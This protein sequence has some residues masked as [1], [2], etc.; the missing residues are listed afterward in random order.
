MHVDGRKEVSVTLQVSSDLHKHAVRSDSRRLMPVAT[1]AVQ[2]AETKAV[3]SYR[4]T[5]GQQK[6]PVCLGAATSD[7]PQ[8]YCLG[9]AC[10]TPRVRSSPDGQSRMQSQWT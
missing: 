6:W 4:D 2:T 8:P 9:G 10:E 5:A 3:S 7:L 1:E